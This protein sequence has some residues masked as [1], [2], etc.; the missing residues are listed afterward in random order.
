MKTKILLFIASLL[1]L[2]P[3]CS[4]I[5]DRPDPSNKQDANFWTDEN[6]LRYYTNEYYDKFFVA[7]GNGYNTNGAVGITASYGFSDDIVYY[8][9]Q[10]NFELS[11]P[12]SR[13]STSMDEVS[14]M[15]SYTGPTWN[16]S[17]I[18]KSNLMIDRINNRM[19]GL[20]NDPAKNHWLGI[21][22]FFRAMNYAGMVTV[23]GDVPY[24]DK[25]LAENDFDEM[26]KPRT[27]RNE[28]MDK[29]Y[30]D[31]KFA[32]ANVRLND[33]DQYVNRYVVAAYVS[34]LALVEGTWQWYHNK[35][36][37]Q[38]QKF[39]EL[40]V[41]AGDLVI[42]SGKFDIV[43]EFR[44][45]FTSKS[46]KD[47]KDC[48]FYRHYQSGMVTHSIGSQCNLNDNQLANG[49][50]DLMKAFICRDG[51]AYQNSTVPNASKLDIQEM[52]KTRDPRFEATFWDKPTMRSRSSLLYNCKFI[53]R[54]SAKLGAAGT[55]PNVYSAAN[56]E[57]DYPIMRYAE[58]L[59]NWIEAK[60]ELKERGV[61]TVSQADIEASINKL[62]NRPLDSEA[63]SKGV[64][65]TA[66][67]LLTALPID[68]NF[69]PDVASNLIWE[70]R[71]ERRM[72][73]AFEHSRLLDLR[74]WKKLEYM[75]NAE[76]DALMLGAWV[77]GPVQMP[78]VFGDIKQAMKGVFA[79][80]D[81]TGTKI[82]WD[83]A[84]TAKM[85]GYYQPKAVDFEESPRQK[86]LNVP[87]VN[88]YL[89]PVGTAQMIQYKS[90]GYKLE[91]TKGWPKFE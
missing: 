13:G 61:G 38:S 59:L 20:L 36:A 65:K 72:E 44:T 85:V 60:A 63:V 31:L 74:R 78:D 71:R 39:L 62:R 58:V 84:N 42:N 23:F 83:G 87:G 80:I 22:R 30:D 66:P 34:R 64:Q 43:T 37:A 18:R 45:L 2:L 33:G 91:Q 73:L 3:S 50:L 76:N 11:V 77:N 51:K 26:Y 81:A 12:S 32:M 14:W 54:E 1:L 15:S 17:W 67:M 25:E 53:D 55:P 40:A 6:S 28:V 69:D 46:L 70:I 86:Y 21:A 5:L 10:T 16:F 57:N 79:V 48:I 56:N 82:V 75:D 29:V 41:E 52:V 7:Y 90:K 24:I 89:S 9:N 88:P 27:P 47:N 49:N 68:P 4:D 19:G 35:D 8:G